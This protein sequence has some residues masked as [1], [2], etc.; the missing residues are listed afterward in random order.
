MKK[1]FFCRF[2]G[3]AVFRLG[4]LLLAGAMLSTF[5]LGG[6]GKTPDLPQE[7]Q[8]ARNAAPLVDFSALEPLEVTPAVESYSVDAELSQIVN[9]DQFYL[10]DEEKELLHQ[11]LFLV[12][13]WGGD[14][15]FSIY[16]MNRYS[17]LPSFVTVDSLIHTYHLYYS[18][19]MNRTEKNYLSGQ[20]KQ[21]SL[22][23]LEAAESQYQALKGSSWEEAALRAVA[24]FGVGARLQDASAPVPDYAASLVEMELDRVRAAGGIDTCSVTGEYMDYTQFIPR[25][26]YEGDPVLEDY[27]RAMMWYGQVNFAQKTD[28]LTRTALLITLALG[29]D[30]QAWEEIYRV[31]GFFAGASDD[32]GYYEYAGAA[33]QAFGGLPAPED[34]PGKESG[35]QAF[36]SL[37]KELEG[38][39]I[40]SVPVWDS[41]ASSQEVMESVKGFRFMGQRLTPDGVIL[42]Q[43]V[44]RAVEE[45]PQ[46][47]Q[48]L[49]PD[50]LD[51]P[52]ALGSDEALD[53][54]EEQGETRYPNYQEQMEM[55]RQGMTAQPLEFWGSSLSSG[56]LYTLL[57]VLTPR[58]EGYPSYMT[59]EQWQRKNLETFAGSYTELKHDTVLYA[60]QV[61]GEMGGGPKPEI[62]D[63]GYVDPQVEVYQRL[64]LLCRQTAQGLKELGM[65]E[66]Q[67]EENL[68]RLAQLSQSLA[69]ISQKE[70]ENQPLTQEEYELILGYGGTLEHFWME[71]VKDR[72]NTDYY[73]PKEIPASLVTDLAT[74]P[75]GQVLQ[76]ANG[77]VDQVLV[78]VPV[79]GTL[80]LA[81]G[82]VFDFYQFTR[83]LDE[84]MTDSQWR[85]LL[86]QWVDESG[87][88]N[89]GTLPEKP[90]WTRDYRV[91][92]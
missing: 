11:N 20:L 80:R 17:Q 27:F 12:E 14:E 86:G 56:W 21:L 78:V 51:V 16:D 57:P 37:I 8:A 34:L 48:R 58:G 9:L 25:G 59:G 29:Q 18:L 19:L 54:L 13:D 4:P 38:P 15:F 2:S 63:R 53:L 44:Y 77:Y 74:D 26:Y 84:R 92:E 88:Y 82:A 52:A 69:I 7:T 61:M 23:M 68:N 10:S 87:W 79:D 32:L 62:D 5:L 55:V 1:S 39:A 31:T 91:A 49:L 6:C 30:S 60:K 76:L 65:L 73:D 50:V 72:A 40:N 46:K 41:D 36:L 45:T 85:Q 67:E 70:L 90:W 71:A 33:A 47:E 43:L 42:Q 28:T 35:Y 83:P 24:F 64:E 89:P 22:T 66:E 75:N 81:V 3:K